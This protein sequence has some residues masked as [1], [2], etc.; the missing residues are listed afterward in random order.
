MST[1]LLPS[2]PYPVNLN[3]LQLSPKGQNLE[4]KKGTELSGF[5]IQNVVMAT[6]TTDLED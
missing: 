5:V 2:E 4:R 3:L 6:Y 1:N